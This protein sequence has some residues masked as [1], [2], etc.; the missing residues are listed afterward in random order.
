MTAEGAYSQVIKGVVGVIHL[1]TDVTFSPNYDDVVNAA[2]SGLRS[3][4]EAAA[5]AGTV[6][7]FVYAGTIV[8]VSVPNLVPRALYDGKDK[9]LRA[10][11]WNTDLIDMAQTL[12]DAGSS[13]PPMA[14]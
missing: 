2:T 10:Q 14:A 8:A 4:L 6:S 13:A 7:R 5:S 1:A 11:D 9:E 3:I 12:R